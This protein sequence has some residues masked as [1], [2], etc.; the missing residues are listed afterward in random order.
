M[1]TLTTL[2]E[3]LRYRVREEAKLRSTV[4]TLVYDTPIKHE[5]TNHANT[6]MRE[7]NALEEAIAIMEAVPRIVDFIER[8]HSCDDVYFS[9]TLNVEAQAL[10]ALLSPSPDD[11]EMQK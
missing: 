5:W 8:A 11:K 4:D 10:L 2:R 3:M 6:L 7:A 9:A 1:D